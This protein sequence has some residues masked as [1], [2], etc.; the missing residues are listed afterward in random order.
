MPVAVPQGEGKRRVLK[1]P[2]QPPLPR[3]TFAMAREHHFCCLPW[4]RKCSQDGFGLP[5]LTCEDTETTSL[6]SSCM[7]APDQEGWHLGRVHCDLRHDPPLPYCMR[8]QH[9][10]RLCSHEVCSPVCLSWRKKRRRKS[11]RPGGHHLAPG[12]ASPLRPELIYELG[13]WRRRYLYQTACSAEWMV[14]AQAREWGTCLFPSSVMLSS[15]PLWH[16]HFCRLMTRQL[17]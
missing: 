13:C 6:N 16:Q 10:R 2:L 9:E 17:R 4:Y 8:P 3:G 5:Y 11:W 15:Y 1:F 7:G 12:P 14:W